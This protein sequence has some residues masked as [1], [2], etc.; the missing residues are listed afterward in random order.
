MVAGNKMVDAYY[1]FCP[2]GGAVWKQVVKS[3]S[4]VNYSFTGINF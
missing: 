3:G 1:Q 4:S 2:L